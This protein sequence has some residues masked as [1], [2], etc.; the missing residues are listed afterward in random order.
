[1]A[2]DRV[3]DSSA[4]DAAMTA[5]ANLIREKTGST[6]KIAWDESTGFTDSIIDVHHA[7]Y[8]LG[9]REGKNAGVYIG[10]EEGKQAEYDAHWDN[11]LREPKATGN[12]AALFSGS[13]WNNDSFNPPCK[14]DFVKNAYNMF[15]YSGNISK[16]KIER[17]I[18]FTKMTTTFASFAYSKV[19]NLPIIDARNAKNINNLFNSASYLVSVDGLILNDNG[20]QSANNSFIA[21]ESLVHIIVYGVIGQ[22]GFDTRYSPLDKESIISFVNALST[23]TTGLTVTF[24]KA[25]VDKAFETSDGANDGSTSPEWLALVAT[26]SNWTIAL[27]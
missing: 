3:V 20:N 13:G 5:T 12:G 14:I 21:C 26:R 8:A 4:L 22:N 2:F 6:E 16:D 15:Y 9:F 19:T 1:M 23:T 18:D 25:A 10:R 27:A 11:I 24:S 7:G 17:Y